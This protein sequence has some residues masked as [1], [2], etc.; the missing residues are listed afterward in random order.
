MCSPRLSKKQKFVVPF[1][2]GPGGFQPQSPL[3]VFERFFRTMFQLFLIITFFRLVVFLAGGARR[4]D[5]WRNDRDPFRG[6]PYRGRWGKEDRNT[7]EDYPP[8]HPQSYNPRGRMPSLQGA[9]D[10]RHRSPNLGPDRY[11]QNRTLRR[12]KR[13]GD[14]SF[15]PFFAPPLFLC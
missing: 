8:G 14:T 13:Q 6:P 7:Y 4:D 2:R 10:S 9:E 12:D 3:G 5:P 1:G 11:E 15:S